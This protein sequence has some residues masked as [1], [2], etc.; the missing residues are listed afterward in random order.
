MQVE[1]I[2]LELFQTLYRTIKRKGLDATLRI[3]KKESQDTSIDDPAVLSVVKV[4]CEEFLIDIN[5]LVY[6]KYV[7]GD[8]KYAIGFCLYFL[9]DD[10]SV[11]ELQKKGLFKY[12]H[13]SVLSRY[14]QL[15]EN[16]DYKHKTDVP[17]IK[18][19]DNLEKKIKELK[20]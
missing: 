18:I 8:N 10:Y 13:K 14:R 11:G 19:K 15:I 2:S 3:L 16:L 5:E 7:R 6:Q 20:K 4:V 17:Y 9:Y 1:E 12:K